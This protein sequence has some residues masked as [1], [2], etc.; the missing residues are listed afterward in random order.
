[1]QSGAKTEAANEPP[2][3]GQRQ[4]NLET[5]ASTAIWAVA[6]TT[7]ALGTIA[8]LRT[9]FGQLIART[10]KA[11]IGHSAVE[12]GDTQ[13]PAA[14]QK[15]QIEAPNEA[16]KIIS[17]TA[18]LPPPP[19]EVRARLEAEILGA[20]QAEQMPPEHE[21]AWLVR[22]VAVMRAMHAHEVTYRLITGGQINLVVAAN[23]F[24]Q[25]HAKARETFNAAKQAFPEIYDAFTFD[26]WLSYPVTRG[27]LSI[28]GDRIMITAL[29]RDFL[30]Y[31]VAMGMTAPKAG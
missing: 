17:P 21:R 5:L 24:P 19:D 28:D 12:F 22:A 8:I 3:V 20:L 2:R 13:A 29:G 23:A 31:L 9:P 26:S 25:T 30:Q 16:E 27:L 4:M 11:G 10:K 14:E 1:M 15:K 6:V 7:I 18:Q